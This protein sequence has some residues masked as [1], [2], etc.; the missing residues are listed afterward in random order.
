MQDGFDAQNQEHV[1]V[2]QRIERGNG[3]TN[4]ATVAEGL[5]ALKRSGLVLEHQEDRSLVG[6]E[7]KKWEFVL[8]GDTKQ[9]VNWED[10]WLV[11]RLQNWWWNLGLWIC[12]C[13]EPLGIVRKGRK[14][15]LL[16][17]GM[18][19]WSMRDGAK[20]GIWTPMYMMVS[21]KPKDWDDWRTKATNISS[22]GP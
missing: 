21:S 5:E 17:Q 8:E 22:K 1:A 16:T 20:M 2:R 7:K 10:W 11:M 6:R 19:V 4:V 15:A 14:E 12:C 9:T 3:I 13:F 18:A